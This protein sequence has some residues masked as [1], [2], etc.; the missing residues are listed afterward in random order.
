MQRIEHSEKLNFLVCLALL[1]LL[2]G[3]WCTLLLAV[4]D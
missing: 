2:L 3:L 4:Y 1:G